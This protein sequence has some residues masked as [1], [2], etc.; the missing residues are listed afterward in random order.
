M[1]FLVAV[2]GQHDSVFTVLSLVSEFDD[3]HFWIL[4]PQ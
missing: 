1:S 3:V 2:W 4:S